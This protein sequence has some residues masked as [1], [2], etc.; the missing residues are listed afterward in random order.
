MRCI[1]DAFSYFDKAPVRTYVILLV[2]RR[3]TAQLR[4]RAPE[5]LRIRRP[6]REALPRH[7]TRVRPRV[8]T[9]RGQGHEPRPRFR[10]KA[11]GAPPLAFVN[12]PL[13]SPPRFSGAFHCGDT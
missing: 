3:A 2:E 10:A 11:R 13:D 1:A 9:L 6:F 5:R 12:R 4:H 8:A 7:E